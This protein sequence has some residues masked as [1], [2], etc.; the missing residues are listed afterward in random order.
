MI[1]KRAE[2]CCR[3]FELVAK[4]SVSKICKQLSILFFRLDLPALASLLANIVEERQYKTASRHVR[5]SV[6]AESSRM[7][8]EKWIKLL[9]TFVHTEIDRLNEEDEYQGEE[10]KVSTSEFMRLWYKNTYT[11]LMRP[12]KTHVIFLCILIQ[13]YYFC[14]I[15]YCYCKIIPSIKTQVWTSCERAYVIE[16]ETN[17]NLQHISL[18]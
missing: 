15:L 5:W 2:I 13:S 8:S 11:H 1:S 6:D 10:L 9:W 7:V 12:E 16:T 18:V 14:G 4:Y 3:N 17:Y